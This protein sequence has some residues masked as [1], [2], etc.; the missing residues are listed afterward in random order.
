MCALPTCHST[1]EL[2][3]VKCAPPRACAAGHGRFCHIL[4]LSGRDGE[5]QGCAPA[6]PWPVVVLFPLYSFTHVNLI[7]GRLGPRDFC[8]LRAAYPWTAASFPHVSQICGMSG[9]FPARSGG[10]EDIAPATPLWL[11]PES[12]T[13]IH[14]VPSIP[15]SSTPLNLF[16]SDHGAPSLLLHSSLYSLPRDFIRCNPTEHHHWMSIA[17]QRQ[18]LMPRPR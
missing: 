17:T 16:V 13:S 4:A 15:L 7:R 14:P 10:A 12:E 3:G 8:M 9:A 5:W 2:R 1:S 18:P 11:V 6:A